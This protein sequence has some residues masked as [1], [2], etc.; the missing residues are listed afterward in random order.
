M[1]T[2][3]LFSQPKSNILDKIA[4]ELFVRPKMKITCMPSDGANADNPKYEAFWKSY[5]QDNSSEIVKRLTNEELL[6]VN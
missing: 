2:Y 6:I 5:I 1:A 3:L 4:S